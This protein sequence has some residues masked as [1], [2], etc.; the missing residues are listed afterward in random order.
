VSTHVHVRI[1]VGLD[2]SDQEELVETLR[3]RCGEEW[4][5]SFRVEDGEPE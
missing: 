4:T 5:R 2:V 1:R 3:C